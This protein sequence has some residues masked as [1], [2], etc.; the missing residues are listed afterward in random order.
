MKKLKRENLEPDT[1]YSEDYRFPRQTVNDAKNVPEKENSKNEFNCAWCKKFFSSPVGRLRHSWHCSWNPDKLSKLKEK[2]ERN[3]EY[4]SKR[5]PSF[6]GR[7]AGPNLTLEEH[8]LRMKT[9]ENTEPD[10]K[11]ENDEFDFFTGNH[12]EDA[13]ANQCQAVKIEL[14]KK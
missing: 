5:K 6:L 8:R 1:V 2:R 10:I 14:D 11:V 9:D 13:N 4:K 7:I 3:R 12:E